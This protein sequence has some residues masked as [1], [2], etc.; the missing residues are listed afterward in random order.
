MPDPGRKS[1]HSLMEKHDSTSC[2]VSTTITTASL[3]LTQLLPQQTQRTDI[4][5]TE[6]REIPL[7]FYI[8]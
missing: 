2:F 5:E 8:F 4:A 7:G 3:A 1:S 6:K